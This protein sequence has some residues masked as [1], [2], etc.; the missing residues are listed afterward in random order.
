MYYIKKNRIYLDVI[1][2]VLSL[3]ICKTC[4]ATF[5]LL[6]AHTRVDYYGKKI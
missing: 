2:L 6:Y 4:T 5:I 1:L 3:V